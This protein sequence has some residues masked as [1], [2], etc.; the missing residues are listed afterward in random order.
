MDQVSKIMAYEQ[1]ELDND[2]TIELFQELV[3][4]GLVWNLQGSYARTASM[5]IEA[6]YMT[7]KEGENDH[8]S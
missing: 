8:R 2:E 1:G 7:R 4:S 6:G 5:L 3:N